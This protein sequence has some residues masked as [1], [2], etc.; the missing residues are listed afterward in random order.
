MRKW[1]FPVNPAREG[2][3]FGGWYS[4]AECTS[5]LDL[6]SATFGEDSSVYAKWII[7]TFTV[8]FDK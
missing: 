2:Y 1:L 5:A 4:D 8:T 6:T 3:T 7:N